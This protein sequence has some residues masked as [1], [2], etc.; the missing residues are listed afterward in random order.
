M[1]NNPSMLRGGKSDLAGGPISIQDAITKT[2]ADAL[3]GSEYQ[4]LPQRVLTGVEPPRD[5]TTGQPI[6]DL[7]ANE[8]RLWYFNNSEAKVQEFSAADLANFRNAMDGLIGDLAAQARIPIYYFRPAAISNISADALIGLDAGLVSKTNDKKDPFGEGHEETIRL[9]FKSIGDEE[10]AEAVDAETV[11]A[12]TESRSE[13]QLAD[14]LTKLA[15]IGV[16]E[17]VLWERYGF[18]PQEIDRMK[19]MKETEA[20]LLAANPPVPPTVEPDAGKQTQP[21]TDEGLPAAA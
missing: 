11:W 18:T 13:A 19:A 2:L 10:K 14:S 5:P 7:K 3:I 8:S 21:P 16:P 15:A 4:S 17:E 9:A 1:P 12:D 6:S 20:L